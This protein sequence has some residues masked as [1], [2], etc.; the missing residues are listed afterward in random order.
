MSEQLVNFPAEAIAVPAAE[1]RT[2]ADMLVAMQAA[3][4]RM[5][6]VLIDRLD[7]ADGDPD[8]LEGD[9]D[10]QDSDGDEKGDQAWLEWHTMR[11]A[12]RNGPN[13]TGANQYGAPLHEDD[14]DDDPA[15]QRDED[16]VN[17]GG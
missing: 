2:L 17:T 6:A 1:L 8:A 5:S 10:E 9:G 4:A 7:E 12:N 15:G 13:R 11:A 16:G 3:C 14:E